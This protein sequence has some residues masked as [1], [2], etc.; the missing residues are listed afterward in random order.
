MKRQSDRRSLIRQRLASRTITVVFHLI[1][2]L[3]VVYG[4]VL[5]TGF[6][7]GDECDMTYSMLNYVP[8][9]VGGTTITTYKLY[10]FVD[11][12]DPRH[13]HLLN[14]RGSGTANPPDIAQRHCAADPFVVLYIP[15]HWGSYT[16][17]RSLGAHGIQLTR[18]RDK[19]EATVLNS[20][21]DGAALRNGIAD[22]EENFVYE[23]YCVDFAEQGAAMHGNLI[24]SQ[25]FYVAQVIK[26][27]STD[28]GIPTV[29]LVGHSIGGLVAKAVAVY[30][31]SV[32][33]KVRNIIT[34][35]TPHVASPFAFDESI[36][37]V[38]RD[39]ESLSNSVLVTSISGGLKDE[40]IPSAL[41][42]ATAG[43]SRVAG[44][45]FGMDHKAIVWCHQALE[46]VRK[47]LFVL[48]QDETTGR[49]LVVE[50]VGT[51]NG[52]YALLVAEQR[53][54]YA[55]QHGYASF[56]AMESAMIYNLD[57]LLIMYSLL[58]GFYLA[59]PNLRPLVGVG[60]IAMLSAF[61]SN[62]HQSLP[63]ML[64]LSLIASSILYGIRK[65]IS[66]LPNKF[67]KNDL[68]MRSSAIATFTTVV[69]LLILVG[70]AVMIAG[71]VIGKTPRFRAITILFVGL[72]MYLSF[73]PLTRTNIF[74]SRSILF[75]AFTLIA[76]PVLT[77]GKL[78]VVGWSFVDDYG[79]ILLVPFVIKVM[80]PIAIRFVVGKPAT[81]NCEQ[82][83][84]IVA[85]A[86]N[87]M[88]FAPGMFQA[89]GTFLV[90]YYLAWVSMIEVAR[91]LS[92]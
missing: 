63:T 51:V 7:N 50:Q 76:I 13:Q 74:D 18:Q 81:R 1:A 64:I 19:N 9:P 41:C 71:L 14:R 73:A 79:E 49:K 60:Y 91:T 8:I 75:S 61:L 84:F 40:L 68:T 6:H 72:A 39:L 35:A 82:P 20:L 38:Y 17:C 22:H 52:S 29:T 78:S 88:V 43:V 16:Q 70:L 54:R 5:R 45:S 46:K 65:V 28:C 89:G 67:S 3:L 34:L 90:G 44:T 2:V 56:V 87:A 66:F 69:L 33:D 92:A 15:G 58:C 11:G 47:I 48:S 31:P 80:V 53:K 42:E 4:L 77:A 10:K 26:Q 62:R 32:R 21:R 86:L 12:R 23:V 37:D 27:L 36:R 30:V 24:R 83:V 55:A 57:L 25:S 59:A 85:H